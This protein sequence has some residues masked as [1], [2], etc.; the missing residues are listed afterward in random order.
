MLLLVSKICRGRQSGLE[1]AY[2]PQFQK[3]RSKR[4]RAEKRA[5]RQHKYSE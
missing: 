1:A 5:N 2:L 3:S 4:V